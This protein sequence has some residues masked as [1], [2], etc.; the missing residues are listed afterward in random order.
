MEPAIIYTFFFAPRYTAQWQRW[1]WWPRVTRTMTKMTTP[2]RCDNTNK[3]AERMALSYTSYM[4][5][6]KC[7][8]QLY[9]YAAGMLPTIQDEEDLR[10]LSMDPAFGVFSHGLCMPPQLL[11]HLLYSHAHNIMSDTGML[12]YIFTTLLL[13]WSH[14]LD[15][16][17]LYYCCLYKIY[18]VN[19]QKLETHYRVYIYAQMQEEEHNVKPEKWQKKCEITFS[20]G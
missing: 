17:T 9:L 14:I 1:W 18:Q 16:G 15:I 6:W 4:C 20:I 13:L 19:E 7:N 8:F 10:W 3:K 12:L 2:T 11:Q 5:N